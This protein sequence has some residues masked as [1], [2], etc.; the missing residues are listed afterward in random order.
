MLVDGGLRAVNIDTG[1]RVLIPFLKAEGFSRIDVVVASHPHSDHI[2]GFV[3]LLERIEVGWYL[4]AGQHYDSWTARRIRTLIREKGIRYAAVEAG[5]RLAGL[6]GV[7]AL[8]LHPT[9]DYVSKNGPA[10]MGLNNGSVVIR[11][12]YGGS[13]VLLTG[14]I[15]HETDSDLLRWGDRLHAQVLKAAHHGSR[16]SSTAAFLNGVRPEFAAVSCGIRNRF[17]HPSPDVI[18]R[19]VA[20]GISIY[21]TDLMGAVEIRIDEEGIDV[22][23]WLEVR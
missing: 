12:T 22:R 2:G 9:P 14:D 6:G 19:Y 15:E 13:A 5:D 20:M 21:R 23:G 16:T 17:R 1:E 8:V 4:D 18:Q 10:P 11:L 7:D 3:T